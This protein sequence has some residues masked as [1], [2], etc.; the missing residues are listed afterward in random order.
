MP[1]IFTTPPAASVASD[2]QPSSHASFG[3]DA[4]QPVNLGGF[5]GA[6][7][8][9]GGQQQ[10]P[11]SFGQSAAGGFGGQAF[12]VGGFPAGQQTAATGGFPAAAAAGLPAAVGG[13]GFSGSTF[14]PTQ[15]GPLQADSGLLAGPT[16]PTSKVKE[17]VLWCW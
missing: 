10:Q 16:Q 3:L 17:G 12:P 1:S 11:L 13:V 15:T 7:S 9:F 5:G 6:G 14:G 4:G 2:S 8:M